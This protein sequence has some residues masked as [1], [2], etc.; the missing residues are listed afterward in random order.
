M[1]KLLRINSAKIL[2]AVEDGIT[3]TKEQ[4]KY[5]QQEKE[6]RLQSILNDVFCSHAKFPMDGFEQPSIV[7]PSPAKV[8]KLQSDCLIQE[9][10]SLPPLGDKWPSLPTEIQGLAQHGDHL[11]LERGHNETEL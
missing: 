5:H 7:V 1:D 2:K 11:E 9:F 8:S 10:N 4:L 6:N 3:R